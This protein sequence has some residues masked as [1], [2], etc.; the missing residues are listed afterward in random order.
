MVKPSFA[1][2]V[3]IVRSLT[4]REQ[5]KDS[6]RGTLFIE[7]VECLERLSRCVHD[8]EASERTGVHLQRVFHD[9]VEVGQPVKIEISHPAVGFGIF[10]SS[11]TELLAYPPARTAEPKRYYILDIDYCNTEVPPP[12][13][14]EQYRAML[15]LIEA[16]GRSA[17]HVDRDSCNLLFVQ[18]SKFELSI[19][20]TAEDLDVLDAG[21]LPKLAAVVAD[22]TQRDQ[23]LPMLS[24]AIVDMLS[25]VPRNE[26]FRFLLGH[27]DDLIRSYEA[28]YRL[29]MASFS[30]EKVRDKVEETRIEYTS[31][32]HKVFSEIQNQILGIPVATVIVATQMKRAGAVGYEFWV[33]ISVLIGTFIFAALLHLLLRNQRHSLDVLGIEIDR[34]ERLL[35]KEYEKILNDDISST[36]TSLKNRLASQRKILA[37]VEWVLATGLT[38]TIIVFFV[39]TPLV[40][41]S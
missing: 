6:I 38:L 17:V 31:K 18:K 37:A 19:S 4:A 8:A 41:P 16:L 26:R 33:N 10:A 40:L 24:N 1:D 28:S 5:L 39:L 36:F 14:I 25:S 32:I 29:F 2:L 15:G 27:L 20:Y 3:W 30:Y 23:R 9:E 35:Q 34:Q 12:K 22:D 7:N 13:P 11:I 21:Y